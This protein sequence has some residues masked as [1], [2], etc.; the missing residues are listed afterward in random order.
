M[1]YASHEARLS[2]VKIDGELQCGL[3]GAG[4]TWQYHMDGVIIMYKNVFYDLHI[5]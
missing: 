4:E 1:H 5:C 3:R 2:F